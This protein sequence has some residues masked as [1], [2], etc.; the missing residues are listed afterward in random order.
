MVGV[1]APPGAPTMKN[2]PRRETI[3]QGSRWMRPEC[4][5]SWHEDALSN[6]M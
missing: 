5:V 3:S 2:E 4:Q 1:L 6:R